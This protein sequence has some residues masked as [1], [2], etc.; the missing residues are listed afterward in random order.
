MNEEEKLRKI[1]NEEMK[2]AIMENLDSSLIFTYIQSLEKELNQEKEKN[3]E[4][5][6]EYNKRV[7]TIIKYE[8]GIKDFI[9][10]TNISDIEPWSE[11]KIKGKLLFE[12]Q[13]LLEE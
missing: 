10:E 7:S 6:E 2:K 12:L 5:F 9:D 1:A 8:Q 4:L 3:K 13:K 11:Y